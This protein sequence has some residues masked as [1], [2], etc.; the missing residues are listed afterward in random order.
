MDY[1]PTLSVFPS[2]VNLLSSILDWSFFKCL[3]N[4]REA[5]LVQ[6]ERSQDP[7]SGSGWWVGAGRLL[8]CMAGPSGHLD[9]IGLVSR[10]N[11]QNLGLRTTGSLMI[12]CKRVRFG[13]QSPSRERVE[14][15]LEGRTAG[16]MTFCLNTKSMRLDEPKSSGR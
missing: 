14:G 12:V 6:A 7:A 2:V 9:V 8:P 4:G 16:L 13:A 5:D 1:F 10:A 3:R 15:T 11:R